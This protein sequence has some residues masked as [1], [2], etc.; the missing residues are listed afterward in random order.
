MKVE[1]ALGQNR[2]KWPVGLK[3]GPSDPQ[4][5]RFF[6]FVRDE[7]WKRLLGI[8]D[9]APGIRVS[10]LWTA[11]QRRMFLMGLKLVNIK[12]CLCSQPEI[13]AK[14]KRQTCKARDGTMPSKH[15][16]QYEPS[17][18][19]AGYSFIACLSSRLGYFTLSPVSHAQINKPGSIL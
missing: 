2:A 10:P 9:L 18:P 5:P 4:G 13:C 3:A 16:S 17:K 8:I 14:E 7:Q 11:K 19:S 15:F 6:S 1:A 12:L